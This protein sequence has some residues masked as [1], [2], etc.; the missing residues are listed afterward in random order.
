MQGVLIFDRGFGQAV[1]QMS[2]TLIFDRGDSSEMASFATARHVKFRD[3]PML[4]PRDADC[5]IIV[6]LIRFLK[7]SFDRLLD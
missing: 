7:D 6:R 1:F 2:S 4:H 3:L 5:C